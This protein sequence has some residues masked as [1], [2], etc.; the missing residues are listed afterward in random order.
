MQIG[1]TQLQPGRWILHAAI[2][3]ACWALAS[4]LHAANND[5]M[6]DA[7]ITNAIETNLLIEEGVSP[8]LIDVKTID[9]VATLSGSVANL[10]EK[11]KALNVARSIKGV[12]SIVDRLG[13]RTAARSEGALETDVTDSLRIDPVTEA[14]EIDVSVNEGIVTLQGTVESW[15]E[16]QLAAR[17]VKGVR[18]VLGV[19]NRIDYEYTE[20]RSDR[21]IKA[22]IEGRLKA[23]S[24]IDDYLIDIEVNDGVVTLSG[25][26]GSLAEKIYARTDAHVAGVK[27]VNATDLKVKPWAADEMQR[28]WKVASTTDGEIKKS[29]RDAFLYDPRVASF[30]I[31]VQVNDGTVT[32]SGTVNN[33]QALRSAERDARNTT[34]VL[35]V[36]NNLKVRPETD[37]EDSTIAQDLR[38]ALAW[39]P[40]VDRFD[41]IVTV[42]NRMAYLTGVV[43]H[44]YQKEQ[45]EDVAARV[46]G[47]AAVLNNIQV[48]EGWPWKSDS[49]IKED[50]HD[51]WAWSPW[52]DGGD[53]TVRVDKGKAAIAGS[54]ETWPELLSAVENA[55]EGGAERVES[56]IRVNEEDRYFNH[57][58]TEPPNRVLP[59]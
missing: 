32:L 50:I 7:E 41:L 31:D 58:W 18:G 59:F 22:D 28:D 1:N 25:T 14:Y 6:S 35:Q 24:Y 16:K 26:V 15:A 10:L 48:Q 29:V 57:S 42:R 17:V 3:A 49:Q 38:E 5:K 39:D 9:G 11:E 4:G 33:L 43:D 53:L 30:N 51:Q 55:F 54:V 8:H 2:V 12:R 20:G 37:I 45:A 40:I 44:E 13:V 19:R 23:D 34:G 52:V 36:E 21:D 46:K 56:Y 27:R 47:V